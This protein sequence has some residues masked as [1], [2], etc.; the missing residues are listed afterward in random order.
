MALTRLHC[1]HHG[2]IQDRRVGS[3]SLPA[4]AAVPAWGKDSRGCRRYRKGQAT[5]CRRERA[6]F[7]G[8]VDRYPS[9]SGWQMAAERQG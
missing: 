1:T 9:G 4:A 3:D 8:E 5:H 6:V 2:H 7:A